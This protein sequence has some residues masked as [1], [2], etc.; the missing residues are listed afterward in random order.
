M[1]VNI[2]PGYLEREV[3]RVLHAVAER[4]PPRIFAVVFKTYWNGWVTTM[5]CKALFLKTGQSSCRCLLGC[6]WDEDGMGHY[7]LCNA[8]WSFLRAPRPRGMG[9]GLQIP[10]AKESALIL[11]DSIGPDDRIRL[12]LAL[13][14]LFT[15]V[16]MTRFGAMPQ[17]LQRSITLL[18]YGCWQSEVR[19]ARLRAHCCTDCAYAEGFL[20]ALL[21]IPDI[22]HL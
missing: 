5:R 16:N 18:C 22:G 8:Y 4:C 15:C 6:G 9:I 11:S 12:A 1:G 20:R 13:Y 10:R 21:A 14:A 7:I 19:V 2:L 17:C 3:L